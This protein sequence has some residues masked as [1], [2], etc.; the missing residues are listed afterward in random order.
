MDQG[1]VAQVVQ[2]T[3]LED[4]GTS[5]EPHGLTELHTVLGQQLGGNAAQSS[6]HGPASVD[7]LQLTVA[8]EGLGVGG[9]TSGI[10]AIVTGVLAGQV[11]GDSVLGVGT[12]PFGAV[13]A[14]ELG[15]LGGLQGSLLHLLQGGKEPRWLV[16]SKTLRQRAKVNLGKQLLP[17]AAAYN[18][19]STMCGLK[20]Q[21]GLPGESNWQKGFRS[22]PWDP[23]VAVPDSC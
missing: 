3:V 9:Q 8:A 2:A 11:A 6:K 15:A 7:Q 13:G 4:L 17:P 20:S 21:P 10:P 23:K 14:V 12:Q 22:N 19:M 16:A 18:Q 1:A 5:L